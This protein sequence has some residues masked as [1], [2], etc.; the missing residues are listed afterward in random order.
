M[1]NWMPILFGI[2]I[3]VLIACM[4]GAI[5][6]RAGYSKSF[7]IVASVLMLVPLANLVMFIVLITKEWPVHKELRA[8]RIRCGEATEQ[9]A[10]DLLCEAIRLESKD[11]IDEALFKHQEVITRFPGT[12]SARDDAISIERIRGNAR[13]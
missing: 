9:D 1:D 10:F 8:L 5:W 13:T 2:L 11:K 3:A 7:S 6:L 4:W 12:I